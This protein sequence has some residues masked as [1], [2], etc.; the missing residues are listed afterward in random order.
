MI[1]SAAWTASA[2]STTRRPASAASARLFETRREP[3]D[4]VDP[5]FVEVQGVGVALAAVADDGDRLAGEGRRIRVVVVVHRRRHRLM[6]SSIELEPRAITTAPVRT[7]S[8]MP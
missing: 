6:A 3:D 1:T 7:N 8:L 2:T 4:D 5:G